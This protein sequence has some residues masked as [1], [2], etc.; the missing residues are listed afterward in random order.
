MRV[1]TICWQFVAGT[2]LGF[3]PIPKQR[4]FNTQRLKKKK[5]S[6]RVQDVAGL[7]EAVPHL[8]QVI[9]RCQSQDMLYGR[10]KHSLQLHTVIWLSCSTFSIYRA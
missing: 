5:D 7:H 10:L 3:K 9:L 4:H 2:S 1:L 6:L 8:G